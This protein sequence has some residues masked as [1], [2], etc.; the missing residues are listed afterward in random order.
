MKAVK[1]LYVDTVSYKPVDYDFSQGYPDVWD[2]ALE[3]TEEEYDN[4]EWTPMMNYMYPLPSEFERDMDKLFGAEWQKK[5]KKVLD[6]TTLVYFHESGDYFLALTGGGMDLSW[7]ICASYI[8]LGYLPPVH[9]CDLPRM[10]GI[11]M[12]NPKARRVVRACL[13]SAEVA[14]IWAN[15]TTKKLKGFLKEDVL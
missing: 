13:R 5:I 1:N 14:G 10:S 2:V 3:L 7:E 6:N 4:Q 12:K 15:Q 11:D 8:G 9:F